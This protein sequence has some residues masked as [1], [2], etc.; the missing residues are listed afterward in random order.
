M[1]KL[2]KLHGSKLKITKADTNQNGVT[3]D[4]GTNQSCFL[5]III[6]VLAT[7]KPFGNVKNAENKRYTVPK[8][9]FF[10]FHFLFFEFFLNKL[11]LAEFQDFFKKMNTN[12]QNSNQTFGLQ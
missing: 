11:L 1:S 9:S 6:I 12:L 8:K 4:K 3:N 2:L 10:I 7:R 5:G